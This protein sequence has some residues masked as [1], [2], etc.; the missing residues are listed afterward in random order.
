[1]NSFE[2]H[3]ERGS[4]QQ[5]ICQRKHQVDFKSIKFKSH[6]GSQNIKAPKSLA[7]NT[8]TSDLRDIN[9]PHLFKIN[10][11]YLMHSYKASHPDD[12]HFTKKGSF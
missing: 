6:Q 12:Y 8:F 10:H 11:P 1:M 2:R 3:L 5:N 4:K 7:S 9:Q